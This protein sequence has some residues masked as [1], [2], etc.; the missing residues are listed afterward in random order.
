MVLKNLNYLAAKAAIIVLTFSLPT[1]Y[2]FGFD[3]NKMLNGMPKLG[4]ESG[5][6]NQQNSKGQKPANPFGALFGGMS[7]P[8]S[9]VGGGSSK[10]QDEKSGASMAGFVCAGFKTKNPGVLYGSLNS[11]DLLPEQELVAKDLMLNFDDAKRLLQDEF[12]NGM[13]SGWVSHFKADY[14]SSFL[15]K[16]VKATFIEY[17]NKPEVRLE[18]AARLKKAL[19]DPSVKKRPKAEAAFA[20]ALILARYEYFHKNANLIN[21]LLDSSYSASNVGA[22]YVKALRM[23]NGYGLQRDVNGAGNFSVLAVR[24]VDELN[25]DAERLGT[26]KLN[27]NAPSDLQTLNLTDPEFKGHKRYQNMAAQGA[28]MRRSIQ[29]SLK[30]NKLPVVRHEAELLAASFDQATDEL[31]E[32]FELSAKVAT[33]TLKFQTAK[34]RTDEKQ[35]VLETRIAMKKSTAALIEEAIGKADA[36]LR[37]EAEVKAKKI[38]S[39]F[40]GLASRSFNLMIKHGMSFSL[41]EDL[42]FAMKTAD[43]MRTDGC[44]FVNAMDSYFERAKVQFTDAEKSTMGNAET[45]DLKAGIPPAD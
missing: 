18:M 42:V 23:Y 40:D 21:S 26:T 43:R 36:G 25:A 33:E 16:K 28:E 37:Q 29:A 6:A 13:W 10:G 2:A 45:D 9:S 22:S 24:R 44:R 15:D 3:L 12:E 8:Q 4:A 20:Y 31:A 19:N 32:I 5:S 41:S 39:R 11:A 27:W 1:S 35:Q 7:A 34:A 38:R 30:S 17:T 14:K